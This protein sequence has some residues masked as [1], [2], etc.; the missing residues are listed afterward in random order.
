MLYRRQ[1]DNQNISSLR[2]DIDDEDSSDGGFKQRIS[3]AQPITR[4]VKRV[5]SVENNVHDRQTLQSRQKTTAGNQ[6]SRLDKGYSS[7][8]SDPSVSTDWQT[9]SPL[10][11]PTQLYFT[12]DRV[13]YRF[14]ALLGASNQCTIVR[15][16]DFSLH[17]IRL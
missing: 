10:K 12:D 11:R 16:G 15:N 3:C 4:T 2:K 5:E 1:I 17:F 6:R 8:D 7:L 13:Y 14:Y 9:D